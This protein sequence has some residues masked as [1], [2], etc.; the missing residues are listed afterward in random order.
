VLLCALGALSALLLML[1]GMVLAPPRA[2]A[3]IP[4]IPLPVLK[5]VVPDL[6]GM[7]SNAAADGF[8]AIL[9]RLFPEV[10]S[11]I[12]ANFIRLF[13]SI[14]DP[15]VGQSDL[16]AFSGDLRTLA[17][18]LTSVLAT[19]GVARFFAAGYTDGRGG[20]GVEA[21]ARA[22]AA[23][24]LIASWPWMYR[25]AML[26]MGNALPADILQ[27]AGGP[28]G[29]A[30][31]LTE[32]HLGLALTTGGWIIALIMQLGLLIMLLALLA[33]RV[34]LQAG[35]T[36][37]FVAMPLAL[38]VLPLTEAPAK[39]V[40][41]ATVA[42]LLVPS[43]WA[44][45]FA[46]V[47]MIG[48]DNLTFRGLAD[49]AF[50]PINSLAALVL[51][52]GMVFLPWKLAKMVMFTGVVSGRVFGAATTQ[53]VASKLVENRVHQE[54]PQ[55]L[56]GKKR[57]AAP[58]PSAGG[59]GPAG[60]GSRVV[61][62]PAGPTG[63]TA[64]TSAAANG[65]IKA[66]AGKVATAG[67]V[68][69]TGG[70]A[71]P[72]AAGSAGTAG[73]AGAS[74]G[75][76]SA[77]AAAGGGAG[78]ASVTPATP[79]A[80]AAPAAARRAASGAGGTLSGTEGGA[81]GAHP[82]PSPEVA[83]QRQAMH[84][85]FSRGDSEQGKEAAARATAD[86]RSATSTDVRAAMVPDAMRHLDTPAFAEVQRISAM[87]SPEVRQSAL[88]EEVGRAAQRGQPDVSQALVTLGAVDRT[89]L[90]EQVSIH[91][92]ARAADDGQAASAAQPAAPAAPQPTAKG[93]S[94]PPGRPEDPRR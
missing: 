63:A 84:E 23:I 7:A 43:V 83:Q 54:V 89:T 30:R 79:A 56:G 15:L 77:A 20:A 34:M 55:S 92:A 36:L 45:C 18:T 40:F 60:D 76:T 9:E 59:S 38:A 67:A 35:T 29:I 62:G 61:A 4:S 2:E 12:D 41:R 37:A 53:K 11:F 90:R 8:R 93:A 58:P 31:G 44:L 27:A 73:A 57:A 48:A 94:A 69:A 1:L 50:S 74:S 64:G 28:T 88:L 52:A 66:A 6:G 25:N 85:A 81:T 19:L 70:A 10:E 87:P 46:T 72:V 42:M 24:V 49:G 65:G 33:M 3:I 80:A 78:V 86:L 13:T 51:M 16:R 71:A 39:A 26:P 5:D 75:A 21:L 22:A 91:Q 47:A 32:M 82:S 68:A 17:L 14:N